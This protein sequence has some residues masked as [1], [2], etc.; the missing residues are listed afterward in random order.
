MFQT[1]KFLTLALIIVITCITTIF[2]VDAVGQK[3]NKNVAGND[4]KTV[5]F[6]KSNAAMKAA[7]KVQADILA[8]KNFGEAMK[9]YKEAEA[10]LNQGKNLDN[11]EK[12]LRE[13]NVYF[14]KAIEATKLAEVTFP[15]SMKA[16]KDAQNTESAKYSSKL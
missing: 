1:K 9:C 4:V 3:Q 14:Q 10:D 15:N 16:R 6:K 12:K 13:S 7:K 5:L 8:P 11:I 2:V